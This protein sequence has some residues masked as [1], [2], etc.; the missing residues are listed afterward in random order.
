MIMNFYKK[1]HLIS[2]DYCVRYST[3]LGMNMSCFQN[4]DRQLAI[5][6]IQGTII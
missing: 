1:F 6:R 5:V 4:V 2:L 3:F